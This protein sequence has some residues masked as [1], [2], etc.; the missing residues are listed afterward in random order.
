MRCGRIREALRATLLSLAQLSRLLLLPSVVNNSLASVVS[1][2]PVLNGGSRELTAAR[3]S[4][5]R[6]G[7]LGRRGRVRQAKPSTGRRAIPALGPEVQAFYPTPRGE[8]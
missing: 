1:A 6:T 8:S 4:A 5:M 3:R 7:C 2:L